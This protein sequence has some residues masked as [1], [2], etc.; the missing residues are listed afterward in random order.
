MYAR[1]IMVNATTVALTLLLG[2]LAAATIWGLA[3]AIT[4]SISAVLAFNFFFLPPVGTFTVEDPQNW[5]ALL[6]FLATAIITSQLSSRAKRRALEA[7]AR[8]QETARLYE[9]GKAILMREELERTVEH[10]LTDVTRI[11]VLK[12][13][14]F[15]SFEDD[16]MNSSGPSFGEIETWRRVA[17]SGDSFRNQEGNRIVAV[18]LGGQPIGSIGFAGSPLS[19]M[20]AEAIANLTAIALER[21]RVM[22]RVALAEAARRSEELRTALVDGMAHDLKTPLTAIKACISGLLP[23]ASQLD[24]TGR[25]YLS[26][27]EEETER[28]QQTLSEA[29]EM[30]RIDAGKLSLHRSAHNLLDVFA[31]LIAEMKV[32]PER[33]KIVPQPMLPPVQIDADLIKL[34]GKQFVDNA[35]KYSPATAPVEIRAHHGVG[36]VEVSVSDEGA[37]ISAE[38]R[39]RIFE[40]F[41]RGRSG[42]A[43]AGGTGMGLAI[44]KGIIEAHGGSVG[45]SRNAKGGSIFSFRLPLSENIHVNE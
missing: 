31:E 40:K 12:F 22:E 11:F 19:P 28:L 29:I 2:V 41:Y 23:R 37:G 38:D 17:E 45:I 35:L 39:P 4:T 43:S 9:L 7:Q 44:A 15:Y 1:L 18:R 5:V 24:E 6:A 16:R 20:V 42:R 3:E 8:A 36:M 13:V 33:I 21:K 25:E 34:A 32:S 30:A 27:I 10:V 14:G 26:I